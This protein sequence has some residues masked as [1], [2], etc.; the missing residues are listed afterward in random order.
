MKGAHDMLGIYP[1]P[2][3]TIIMNEPLFAAI[4]E[5]LLFFARE[6]APKTFF[7]GIV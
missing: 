2:L 7:Y 6:V 4:A 3:E 5:I 1:N